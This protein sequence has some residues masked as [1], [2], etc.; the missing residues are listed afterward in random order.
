V[1]LVAFCS[2]LLG[3][4][5]VR[6]GDEPGSISF[7]LPA[8]DGGS[9]YGRVKLIDDGDM[10][11]VIVALHGAAEGESYMPHIHAGTCADY[12]GNP[13]FPL[14]LFTT[15]ERSRTTVSVPLA[16][17]T[18]G[19]YIVDIHPLAD[20]A[21]DLFDASTAVV[22]GDLTVA[23]GRE[24]PGAAADKSG[25]VTV[26]TPPNT[27]VGPIGEQYWSTIL[28]IVLAATAVFT[29]TIGLDLRRRA[30]MTLATRRLYA[31]TGRRP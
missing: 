2:L 4:G 12:D 15:P 17:L 26:T 18:G 16:T 19:G 14:L 1:T 28:L 8:T 24:S 6:A 10:T 29:A 9:V 11:R 25:D 22:C 23:T 7:T 3:T 13:A 27:G 30:T 20:N 31:M 21:G 5:M